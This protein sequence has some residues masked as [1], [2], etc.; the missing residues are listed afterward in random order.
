M[1]QPKK[2]ADLQLDPS[3]GEKLKAMLADEMQ[4]VDAWL[5]K[6][7]DLSRRAPLGRNPVGEAMAAKF[8]NRAGDGSNALAGVLK[9]YRQ[10]LQ[11]TN[12]AVATAM[13]LYQ[14][15][16]QRAVSSLKTAAGEQ[17]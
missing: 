15:T 10:I 3:A 2:Q 5:A 11:E 7:G 16:E 4:Q 1:N 17:A 12:D 9:S 13:N 8:A 6:A 14:G